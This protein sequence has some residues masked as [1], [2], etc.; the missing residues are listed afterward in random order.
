MTEEKTEETKDAGSMWQQGGDQN[1]APTSWGTA[2]MMG[3]DAVIEHGRDS[4]LERDGRTLA[5]QTS[6]LHNVREESSL[7]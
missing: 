1:E 5:F 7:F 2:K 4:P 6:L 3:T